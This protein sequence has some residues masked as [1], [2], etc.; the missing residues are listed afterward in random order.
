MT[1]P[2]TDGRSLFR[3]LLPVEFSGAGSSEVMVA[4]ILQ[5]GSASAEHTEQKRLFNL[6]P[7]V[8]RDSSLPVSPRW[9]ELLCVIGTKRHALIFIPP[10][11]K[12]KF[13]PPSA[14]RST[15]RPT[16]WRCRWKG[17]PTSA[18]GRSPRWAHHGLG[19]LFCQRFCDG[20]LLGL[21]HI[22]EK[23]CWKKKKKEQK[24]RF[25]C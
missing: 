17:S 5:R 25:C 11:A 13:R 16:F 6:P 15:G 21:H 1:S 10:G 22:G 3:F 14:S 4:V 18:G 23:W 12:R 2:V 20:F 8:V 19:P 7:P 9:R 24:K